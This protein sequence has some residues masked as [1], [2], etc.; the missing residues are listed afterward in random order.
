MCRRMK[1]ETHHGDIYKSPVDNVQLHLRARIHRTSRFPAAVI[2]LLRYRRL[3]RP[4]TFLINLGTRLP[5]FDTIRLLRIVY[6]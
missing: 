2:P 4:K 1:Y 6:E 3:R 5:Q